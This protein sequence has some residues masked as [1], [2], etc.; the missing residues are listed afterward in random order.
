M[1]NIVG[2]ILA[3]GE[4]TRMKSELPKV[5]H[6]LCDKPMLKYML[7]TLRRLE[8]TKG[9]VVVGYQADKVEKMLKGIPGIQVLRQKKLLGSADAVRQS[10]TVFS[11]FKGDVLVIYGDTP[12]VS[13]QSL[14]KLV[15]KHQRN[16]ASCTL[17]T[18]VLRNPTGFGRIIRTEDNQIARIVEEQ[19]AD[20]YEKAVG[21]IN[22]GAYCFKSRELFS[23]IDELDCNNAKKEYYLTDTIELLIKKKARIESVTTADEQEAQG[24]NSRSDLSRAH[25]IIN[26]RNI[27]RLVAAG[28][29]I[30]DP[31]TTYL[32]AEAE[33]GRD[34]IIYP[35]TLIEGKV[36]IGS[37][38]KIGPFAHLRSGTILKDKVEIG[39]FVEV[40]RSQIDS[41]TK[42]K[43]HSYIGDAT[44]GKDVNIGAGTI[45]A[46][47]DG[48]KKNRTLIGDGVF[49]GVGTI[50]I[51][52][53][54]VGKYAV[55]GAGCVVTKDQD[56]PAGKTVVGIP[57]R[58]L[59]KR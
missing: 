25:A 33:I 16:Q 24:I 57:A 5:L 43:H 42:I 51:A 36:K 46:N 23:A 59:K 22:V 11:N 10:K 1:K 13:Y 34:T 32:Y 35:H 20:T 29:T 18:A 27:D 8:I 48:K 7:E 28:V 4:G 2:I 3:A 19:D 52:P 26:K 6:K 41:A 39:N 53:V 21:E 55:T 14:K 54:K 56:V 49:I 31:A 17:L 9:T 15:Q 45:T 44:I 58:I 38:C 30:V 47:Y 40:V 50:L 37:S 12:L